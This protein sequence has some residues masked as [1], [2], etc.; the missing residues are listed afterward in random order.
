M[1]LKPFYMKLRALLV[2]AQSFLCEAVQARRGVIRFLYLVAD[3][4]EAMHATH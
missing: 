4:T 3:L 1:P 2:A